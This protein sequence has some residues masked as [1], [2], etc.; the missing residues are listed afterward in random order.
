VA[1]LTRVPLAPA[2]FPEHDTTIHVAP[3]LVAVTFPSEDGFQLSVASRHGAALHALRDPDFDWE[4]F[5]G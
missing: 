3:G 2:T 5:N 4:A 1:R